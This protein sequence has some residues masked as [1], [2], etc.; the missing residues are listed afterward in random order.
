MNREDRASGGL[1]GLVLA[2]VSGIETM[3]SGSLALPYLATG[4]LGVVSLIVCIASRAP[5]M[6]PE[7]VH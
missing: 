6:P 5:V 1:A 4:L 3:V 2:G 7:P